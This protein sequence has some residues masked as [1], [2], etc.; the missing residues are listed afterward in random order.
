MC[1]PMTHT[2]RIKAVLVLLI[3]FQ[4]CILM[5]QNYRKETKSDIYKL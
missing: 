5:I 1:N 2:A 3:T 4:S